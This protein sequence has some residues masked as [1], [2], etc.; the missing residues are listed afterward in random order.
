M[1][2]DDHDSAASHEPGTLQTRRSFLRT[3]VLGAAASWTLP[4]FI[5]RTFFALNAQAENSA[6]QIV[7]GKDGP[8]LVVLQQ[9]GG[10]DGLNMLPSVGGRRLSSR[11]AH[12]G[13]CRRQGAQAGWLLRTASRAHAAQGAL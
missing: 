8:I 11:P 7:T 12:P 6:T 1:N 9:A 10:N 13:A 5:D 2:N 4:A 3:S